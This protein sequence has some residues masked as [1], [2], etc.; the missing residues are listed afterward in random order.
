LVEKDNFDRVDFVSGDDEAANERVK[1]LVDS[2]VIEL[3][4]EG[5]MVATLEP[6]K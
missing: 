6:E 1:N 3:W 5:R 2:H 4:H